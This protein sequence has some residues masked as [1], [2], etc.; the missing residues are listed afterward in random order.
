VRVL[1]KANGLLSDN[2]YSLLP[3]SKGNLWIGSAEGLS[4]S[5]HGK[6]QNIKKSEAIGNNVITLIEDPMGRIW[7]GSAAGLGLFEN[8]TGRYIKISG[9]SGAHIVVSLLIENE[10]YLWIGTERG[11]FRLDLDAFDP[12][13]SGKP[14]FEYYSQKDGLPSLECNANAIYQDSKG[15]IWFGTAGGASFIPAGNDRQEESFQPSVY[16]T[17]VSSAISQDSSWESLGFQ[18]DDRGLPTNLKLAHTDNRVDIDFIGLSL[19]SPRQVEY[20]IWMEGL[21]NNWVRPKA[22]SL[23]Y[24]NLDPG[25]YTIKVTAKM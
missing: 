6:I 21:D 11:V 22:L 23:S 18:L 19:K 25:I 13:A 3:D 8:E 7:T 10:K 20:K 17:Q 1:N 2:I 9:A 5:K 12:M 16:I 15:N 24:P 14:P 4:I